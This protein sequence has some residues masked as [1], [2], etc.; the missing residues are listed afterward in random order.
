MKLAVDLIERMKGTFDHSAYHDRY[1][2]R[3]TAIIDKKRKGETITA[4]KVEERKAPSDL[5]AA[6]EASLSDAVGRSKAK[7]RPA[8]SRRNAPKAGARGKT[9]AK[10]RKKAAKTAGT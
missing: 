5:M 6:L 8:A 2:E 4:P 3:L 7:K 1:R 9:S 10:T